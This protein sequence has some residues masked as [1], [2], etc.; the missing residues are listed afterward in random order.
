MRDCFACDEFKLNSVGPLFALASSYDFHSKLP[1]ES[2]LS[3]WSDAEM[4]SSPTWKNAMH[5]VNYVLNQLFWN[6]KAT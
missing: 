4:G 2:L 3:G 6:N 5:G 1:Q